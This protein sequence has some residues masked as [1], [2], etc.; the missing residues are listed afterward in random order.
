M[1]ITLADNGWTPIVSEIDLNTA[2]KEEIDIIGCLTGRQTLVVIKNQGHLTAQDD[3]VAV[4]RFGSPDINADYVKNVVIDGTE[5]IMRRVTGKKNPDGKWSGIFGMKEELNWHANPVEDPNRRPVVYL[6]AVTG[7]KG[8]VTS[9]TNHAR[10]WQNNISDTLKE[11][12]LNNDLHVMHAHDNTST[13]VRET[14]EALYDGSVNRQFLGNEANTPPL[15]HKNKFGAIGPFISW[16]QFDKFV[17]L[18]KEKSQKICQALKTEIMS[19]QHNFYD[20][21]WEDGDLLLS[22]QWLGLHKRHAFEDIENRLLHRAVV[23]YNNIDETMVD[24]ALDLIK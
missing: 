14:M 2:T 21:H 22:D 10:A 17:E 24:K 23:D 20:H 15:L 6:R 5:R 3:V 16:F 4:K 18:D 12:I 9:F 19:D 8:S 7:S 13:V 11:F 1:K